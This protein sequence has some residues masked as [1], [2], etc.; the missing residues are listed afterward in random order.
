MLDLG[1]DGDHPGPRED[2]RQHVPLPPQVSPDRH[3]VTVGAVKPEGNGF[4]LSKSTLLAPFLWPLPQLLGGAWGRCRPHAGGPPGVVLDDDSGCPHL[5]VPDE[6]SWSIG[7]AQLP[8]CHR[9]G[10]AR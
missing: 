7:P 2:I 10:L 8:A 9:E 1:N 5:A 4:K 6:V 3:K